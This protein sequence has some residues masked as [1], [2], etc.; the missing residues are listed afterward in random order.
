MKISVTLRPH[1]LFI[2]D[3]NSQFFH[4]DANFLYHK[5]LEMDGLD[6]FHED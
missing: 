2:T 6:L 3:R 1:G 5:K 4:I